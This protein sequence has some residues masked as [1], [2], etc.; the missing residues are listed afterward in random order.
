MRSS[1]AAVLVLSMVFP[2]LAHAGS[3]RPW[4]GAHGSMSTYSMSDVNRDISNFNAAI[5]GSGLSMD[6]IHG[7]LGLGMTLGIDLPSPFS[8]GVGY[9]R[10]SAST[11]VGDASG[12]IKYKFPANAFRAF[13]QYSFSGA[14]AS[15]GHIGGALGLI[16]EAGSVTV[17]I[18]GQTPFEENVHGSGALF[19]LFG[20]GDWWASPQ[21]AITGSAG[22][23]YA[24]INEIKVLG[25]VVYISPGE[26]ESIDYS[27]IF[28][29]VGI[30]LALAK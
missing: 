1:A 2:S 17:E 9:D 7:G 14:G 12:S 22:Y 4:F 30:K 16:N 29:R 25:E 21:F 10:L 8:I 15:R 11:D 27:G 26:K 23:R 5:A 18:T 13:G 20:G 6:E 28:A 19:E 24:K 3:V